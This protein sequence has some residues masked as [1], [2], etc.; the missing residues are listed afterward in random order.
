MP[1]IRMVVGGDG[2]LRLPGRAS[3]VARPAGALVDLPLEPRYT[4]RDTRETFQ[5]LAMRVEG[6]VI[7]RVPPE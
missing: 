7:L 2:R 6:S 5:G 1:S 4:I 3:I